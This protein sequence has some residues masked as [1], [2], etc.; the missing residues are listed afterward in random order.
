MTMEGDG[1]CEESP[2]VTKLY[3]EDELVHV[4]L[5][6]QRYRFTQTSKTLTP[7]T[8]NKTNDPARS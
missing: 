5:K 1:S 8:E 3:R 2:G 4:G 6:W 7:G